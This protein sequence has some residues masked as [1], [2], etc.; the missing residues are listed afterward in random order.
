[1]SASAKTVFAL[2]R[3]NWRWCSDAALMRLPG[4]TRLRSYARRATAL[5]ARAEK[6]Q[7]VRARANPFLCGGQALHYQT[8]LAP[9]LLN[10]WA[11]DLGLTP[12]GPAASSKAWAGWWEQQQGAFTPLQRDKMWE[13]L[14]RLRFYEVVEHPERPV[15]YVVVRINWA[16]NDQWFVAEAEGGAPE[17]VFRTRD[18]AEAYCQECNELSRD[19]WDETVE[20]EADDDG[21][22][23]DMEHRWQ[24]LEPPPDRELAR[25]GKHGLLRLGDAAFCEVVE[26]EVGA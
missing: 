6:E 13:A 10:D 22:A 18:E 24:A 14:D 19:F 11:L 20:E 3:L 8:S 21:G 1:M 5:K 17:N 15:V 16:Y 4:R 9:G 12:P 26:V 23:F 2:E 7:A 25:R